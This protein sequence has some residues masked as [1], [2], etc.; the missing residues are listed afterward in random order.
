MA[1]LHASLVAGATQSIA[2][3][4]NNGSGKSTLAAA[5]ASSGLTILSDDRLFLDFATCRP[6][7]TPNV[8]RLKRGSWSP[9]ISRYPELFQIPVF[10][11]DDGEELRLLTLP[12]AQDPVAP[13]VAQI[14]F[15]RYHAAVVTAAIPLTPLQALERVTAAEGWITSELE[16]LKRFLQWLEGVRCYDLPFSDLDEALER[17]AR[18]E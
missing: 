6:V 16:K 17:I 15:P 2:I 1:C 5:L 14:F 3:V 9:L 18:P 11:D 4:G 10:R 12:P 13:D 8:I 7:A